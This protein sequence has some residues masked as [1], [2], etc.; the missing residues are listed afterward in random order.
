MH[1]GGS[2]VPTNGKK[3]KGRGWVGERMG[4]GAEGAT[5]SPAWRPTWAGGWL[6]DAGA[7]RSNFRDLKDTFWE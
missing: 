4:Q 3:E 2:R 6:L 7:T 5:S 1:T